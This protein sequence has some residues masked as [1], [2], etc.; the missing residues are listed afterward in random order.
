MGWGFKGKFRFFRA[1]TLRK[2]HASNIGL[3]EEHVDMLQGRS[4]DAV[5]DT[6]IKSNPKHL[7]Q[8]YM[9]AMENVTI[10]IEN[11]RTVVNEDYT[12]SIHLHFHEEGLTSTL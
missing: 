2:F 4:K 1:H 7:K 3:S 6:Y 11:Q 12:I 5:H 8:I 9:N 10:K